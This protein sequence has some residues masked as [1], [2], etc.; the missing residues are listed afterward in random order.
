MTL[1]ALSF[2]SYVSDLTSLFCSF[3]AVTRMGTLDIGRNSETGYGFTASMVL[4]TVK[5][6]WA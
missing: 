5:K 6:V 4:A 2:P 3:T 1:V